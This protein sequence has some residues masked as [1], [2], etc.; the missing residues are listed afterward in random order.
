MYKSYWFYAGI[1]RKAAHRRYQPI[2]KIPSSRISGFPRSPPRSVSH[3]RSPLHASCVSSAI[4][5]APNLPFISMGVK[6]CRS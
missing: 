5:G 2:F 1:K 3:S 4:R 6:Y